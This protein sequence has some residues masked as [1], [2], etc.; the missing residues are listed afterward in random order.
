M[1]TKTIAAA[2]A[3]A[4]KLYGEELWR[5]SLVAPFFAPF[6]GGADAMINVKRQLE[7]GA[8]SSIKFAYINKLVGAYKTEGQA[9]ENNEMSFSDSTMDITLGLIKG[10]V[11]IDNEMSVQRSMY[12]LPAEAKTLISKWHTETEDQI[13]MNTLFSGHS[14]NYWTGTATASTDVVDKLTLTDLS[15]LAIL[16]ETGGGNRDFDPIAPIKVDGEKLWIFLCHP[17]VYY[18]LTTTDTNWNL[19]VR[20]ARERSASNPLFTRVKAKWQNIL[21]CTSER[22]PT[23]SNWSST[24]DK[25]GA[26]SMLLGAQALFMANGKNPELIQ[27][28]FGYNETVGYAI[29]AIYTYAR[30]KF[31]SFDQASIQVNSLATG[32][33]L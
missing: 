25:V 32:V 8:G 1:A 12:D 26:E 17:N 5:Q 30:P 22:C 10:A 21:V 16:A 23:Y 29:K 15:K 24:G 4:K 33:S 27:K 31:G 2:D 6:K 20:E 13:A 7:A 18:D 14:N 11:R 9:L 28:D 3:V 19:A